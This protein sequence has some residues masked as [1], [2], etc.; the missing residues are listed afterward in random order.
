M[1]ILAATGFAIL[2][3]LMSAALQPAM[4]LPRA[5]VLIEGGLDIDTV[6]PFFDNMMNCKAL[7]GQIVP[8]E[9]VVHIE[10]NGMKDLN[11][12]IT[13]HVFGI[14]GASRAT[15]WVMRTE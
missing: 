11:A 5:Y 4:A 14:E 13:N 6:R 1:R 12:A 3:S 9:V 8:S 10:C 15:I 7:F 2:V